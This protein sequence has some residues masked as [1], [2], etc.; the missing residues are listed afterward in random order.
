M[1]YFMIKFFL[2]PV[3]SIHN[4]FQDLIIEAIY[5]DV[6]HGKLDQQNSQV[7]R[8]SLCFVFANLCTNLILYFHIFL[9]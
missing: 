4:Q 3:N 8:T 7:E 2:K 9:A 6:I 5:A 1:N